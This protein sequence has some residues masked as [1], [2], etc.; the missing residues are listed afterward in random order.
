MNR[1]KLKK[2]WREI[3]DARRKP[4]K[5]DDLERLARMAERMEYAG[6]NHPMWQSFFFAHRAFPIPRHGGN[7]EVGDYVQKVVLD[8][9]EMDAAAWEEIVTD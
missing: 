1:R 4:Q 6:A 7:S 9:L 3:S 2:L 8:H 5:A